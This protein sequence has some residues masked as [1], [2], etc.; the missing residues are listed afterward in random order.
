MHP[1][2]PTLLCA[3]LKTSMELQTRSKHL[4]RRAQR[5]QHKGKAH[6]ATFMNPWLCASFMRMPRMVASAMIYGS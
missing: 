1:T 6:L 4:Q 3:P 2:M 5:L